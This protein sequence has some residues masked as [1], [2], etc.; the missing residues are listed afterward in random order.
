MVHRTQLVRGMMIIIG[1]CFFSMSA[2]AGPNG[3][4]MAEKAKAAKLDSANAASKDVGGGKHLK[5]TPADLSHVKKKE[6]LESGQFIGTFETDMDGISLK[7]GTYNMHVAKDGDKWKVYA[8]QDGKIVGEKNF[9]PVAKNDKGA[10][11]KVWKGS[12]CF[13]VW[14][15]FFGFQVCW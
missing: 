13:W 6:D 5:M 15:V 7:P 14:L 1:L 8:E 11:A 2:L 12:G 4:D 3:K 10:K 9:D